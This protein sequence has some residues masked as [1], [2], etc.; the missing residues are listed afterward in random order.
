MTWLECDLISWCQDTLLWVCWICRN[1]RDQSEQFE[2]SRYFKQIANGIFPPAGKE[3]LFHD[4]NEGLF[5]FIPCR[6]SQISLFEHRPDQIPQL[7]LFLFL[8]GIPIAIDADEEALG[9]EKLD[10]QGGMGEPGG[11]VGP[12][13][14][15]P[16]DVQ[17]GPFGPVGVV[18]ANFQWNWAIQGLR[19][20]E[21]RRDKYILH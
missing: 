8:E 12:V 1:G 14:G 2:I 20:L 3:S 19:K 15:V 5:Q 16:L 17:A 10:R 9:T 7:D 13:C 21:M 11:N 4:P 18:H 6:C